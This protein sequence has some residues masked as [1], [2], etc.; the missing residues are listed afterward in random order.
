MVQ[1]R[2][3]NTR[4]SACDC[5]KAQPFI[6][7]KPASFEEPLSETRRRYPVRTSLFSWT[8]MYSCRTVRG[9]GGG[10]AARGERRK[11]VIRDISGVDHRG[12]TNLSAPIW[13]TGQ[14]HCIVFRHV[15]QLSLL[16]L[17]W[18]ST[19]TVILPQIKKKRSLSNVGHRG[20]KAE[21]LAW[22][23]KGLNFP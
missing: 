7:C 20:T 21:N 16:V 13:L 14:R 2:K 9:G 6:I 1:K 15:M 12:V 4:K 5:A 23:S 22:H 3:K 17:S 19:L 8:W 10:E 18:K 11:A